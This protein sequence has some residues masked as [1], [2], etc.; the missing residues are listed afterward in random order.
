MNLESAWWHAYN[1]QSKNEAIC[2]RMSHL[3]RQAAYL[4]SNA[5]PPSIMNTPPAWQMGNT[6][7]VLVPPLLGSSFRSH[8]HSPTGRSDR[9]S[10]EG[11]QASC[12]AGLRLAPHLG[13]NWKHPEEEGCP[14][15]AVASAP[16]PYNN[17]H[18]HQGGTQRQRERNDGSGT[19]LGGHTSE[20][21]GALRCYILRAQH[22]VTR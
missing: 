15:A 1:Q 9:T 16:G 13:W 3:P 17:D 20:H 12:F 11:A 4:S 21:L 5:L 14:V 2:W 10:Q 19:Q 22:L 18:R 8:Q 7:S 6:G